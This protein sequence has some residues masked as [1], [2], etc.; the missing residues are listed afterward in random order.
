M[1]LG[2]EE[3]YQLKRRTRLAAGLNRLMQ[4]GDLAD[5]GAVIGCRHNDAAPSKTS[6]V[7]PFHSVRGKHDVAQAE[8]LGRNPSRQVIVN[9]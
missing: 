6:F 7:E 3:V 5:L 8:G 1:V 4:A 2:N 9:D